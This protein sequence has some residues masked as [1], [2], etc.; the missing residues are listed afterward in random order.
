MTQ[1]D[2]SKTL[3]ISKKAHAMITDACIKHERYSEAIIR[4]ITELN[5]FKARK[6]LPEVL[7]PHKPVTKKLKPVFNQ[8]DLP[9]PDVVYEEDNNAGV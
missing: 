1:A 3:R 4:V 8:W 2:T 9:E 5:Y 7:L 6:K